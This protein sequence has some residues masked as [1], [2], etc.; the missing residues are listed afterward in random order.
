MSLHYASI[1]KLSI[2][3]LST[4][5]LTH[6]SFL[7]LSCY[8]TYKDSGPRPSGLAACTGS[9]ADSVGTGGAGNPD[10]RPRE[11]AGARNRYSRSLLRR[12]AGVGSLFRRN[13]GVGSLFRRN[14][15]VGSDGVGSRRRRNDGVGYRLRRNARV[16]KISLACRPPPSF[17]R[18]RE[19]DK[20]VWSRAQAALRHTP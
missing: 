17:R 1:R 2:T 10:S 5:S 18:R 13:A 15:G 16:G 7:L 14:A 12:N 3:V 20:R 19:P 9:G 11:A 8:L 6:I 4:L